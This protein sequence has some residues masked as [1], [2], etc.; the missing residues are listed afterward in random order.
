M[1]GVVGAAAAEVVAAAGAAV[2]AASVAAD[3][4]ADGEGRLGQWAN[5]SGVRGRLSS[6]R[7]LGDDGDGFLTA[8]GAVGAAHRLSADFYLT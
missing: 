5:R 7:K 3:R 6:A 2:A 1:E 4:A 8:C